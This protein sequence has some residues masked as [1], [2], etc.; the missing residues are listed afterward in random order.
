MIFTSVDLPAP[1]S[2]RR[3]TIA[4]G[5]TSMSTPASAWTRPKCLTTPRTSRS[6][7]PAIRGRARAFASEGAGR[8]R[9]ALADVFLLGEAVL[10]HRVLDV[11][12]VDYHR[13]EK[14]GGD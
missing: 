6:G 7:S 4:P 14:Q 1:L 12:L 5:W 10:D 8:R 9:G 13:L 2:P 11:G 3:A